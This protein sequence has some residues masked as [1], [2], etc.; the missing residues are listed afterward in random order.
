MTFTLSGTFHK[1]IT[2]NATDFF[3]MISGESAVAAWGD[4][5]VCNLTTVRQSIDGIVRENCPPNRGFAMLTLEWTPEY[6]WTPVNSLEC[7]IVLYQ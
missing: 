2:E 4:D 6:Y 7:P 3:F 5:S 1:P